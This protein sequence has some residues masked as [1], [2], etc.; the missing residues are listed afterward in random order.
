MG[1][2]LSGELSCPC[3]RSCLNCFGRKKNSILQLKKYGTASKTSS[4][5]RRTVAIILDFSI[6]RFFTGYHILGTR[7][8]TRHVF[9]AFYFLRN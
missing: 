7:I 1:K 9:L 6:F 8:N 5:L 4:V 2:A 3:D